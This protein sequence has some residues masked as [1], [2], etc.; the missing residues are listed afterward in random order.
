M[1]LKEQFSR[2]TPDGVVCTTPVL[3]FAGDSKSSELPCPMAY[4]TI[5]KE[6]APL[7]VAP[8]AVACRPLSGVVHLLSS[9]GLPLLFRLWSGAF[10][11]KRHCQ[12]LPE[13]LPVVHRQSQAKRTWPA[14]QKG[15]LPY[16]ANEQFF[17]TLWHTW[18]QHDVVVW[19]HSIALGETGGLEKKEHNSKTWWFVKNPLYACTAKVEA[20]L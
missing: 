16:E 14:C 17:L 20:S 15:M 5:L 18:A 6:L 13:P 12:L 7:P 8:R 1:K 10:G 11:I 4:G 2:G 3:S 19:Q 9:P